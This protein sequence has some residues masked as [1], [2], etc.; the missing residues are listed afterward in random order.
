MIRRPPR[1]TLFPYT[2]LFRS[3][4]RSHRICRND[5]SLWLGFRK[6]GFVDG[7][8]DFQL[9]HRSY[10]PGIR[11]LLSDREWEFDSAHITII[12]IGNARS[13]LIKTEKQTCL[14]VK[15]V[16]VRPSRFGIVRFN[17]PC[18]TTLNF[19]LLDKPHSYIGFFQPGW[20]C[21][22]PFFAIVLAPGFGFELTT[23]QISIDEPGYFPITT[24]QCNY[25]VIFSEIGA[26]S[27][28]GTFEI[29]LKC[30]ALFL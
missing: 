14:R 5:P 19:F 30:T 1:S 23:F 3:R 27:E 8:I 25:Q 15:V 9:A 22:K 20:Y 17:F 18:H 10:E 16:S 24:V 13:R 7:G 28:V 6:P 29:E 2:T 21:L 4:R 11:K 26:E 12:R